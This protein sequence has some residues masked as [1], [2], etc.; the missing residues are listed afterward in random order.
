V[1]GN[2]TE[3]QGNNDYFKLGYI[4][5]LQ[6][7]YGNNLNVKTS[8]IR[9]VPTPP[10]GRPLLTAQQ[11]NPDILRRNKF[12][13]TKSARPSSSE[14]FTAHP[15][16]LIGNNESK[17]Q[18]RTKKSSNWQVVFRVISKGTERSIHWVSS[19]CLRCRE[20]RES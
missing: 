16:S 10:G 11:G 20:T 4:C 9:T 13:V 2:N 17:C 7:P 18:Q 19:Y 15:C 3:V 5:F 12:F 6:P 8:M 1:L 14:S